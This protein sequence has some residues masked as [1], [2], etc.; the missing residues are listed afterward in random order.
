M[1]KILSDCQRVEER[2]YNISILY[3]GTE[4]QRYYT[5][6][7][8]IQEICG[9]AKNR[10]EISYNHKPGLLLSAAAFVLLVM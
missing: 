2:K 4:A 3:T 9:R 7:K 8:D 1:L 10:A 5:S 6:L